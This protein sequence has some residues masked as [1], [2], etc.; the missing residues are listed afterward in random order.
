MP[1]AAVSSSSSVEATTAAMESSTAA[2]EASTTVDTSEATG[3]EAVSTKMRGMSGEARA[4]A[5][6]GTIARPKV[7]VVTAEVPEARRT[8]RE[9]RE[10]IAPAKRT[11]E[12][13]IARDK[14]ICVESGIPNTN[15]HQ[16]RHR[17]T[18]RHRRHT[19]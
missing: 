16:P 5:V 9:P 12:N 17:E 15:R 1:T 13:S 10:V 2:A 7:I 19:F 8:K 4:G 6:C 3:T 18:N 11:V 14:R